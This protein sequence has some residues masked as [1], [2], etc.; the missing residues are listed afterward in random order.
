MLTFGQAAGAAPE[1]AGP[2]GTT[3]V[4]KA[5]PPTT[6]GPT[7]TATGPGTATGAT[8]TTT[9]PG[10][11]TTGADGEEEPP[12]SSDDDEGSSS[13]DEDGDGDSIWGAAVLGL[14][15]FGLVLAYFF[16][17][18]WRSSYEKLAKA[19]LEETHIFPSTVWGERAYGS[20]D[21]AKQL[22]EEGREPPEQPVVSGPAALTV[23]QPSTYKAT[24]GG[25]P[26]SD[27]KW[28]I[29]SGEIATVSPETGAEVTVTATKEGSFILS[30]ESGEDPGGPITRLS[31][32]AVAKSGEGGGVPLLGTNFA[33]VSIVIFAVAVTGG[34]VALGELSAEA[35]IAFLGPVIGYFFVR[36]NQSSST[37]GGDTGGS[38]G[39]SPTK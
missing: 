23:G 31:L 18:R 5:E 1:A 34:L 16:Y 14:G 29:D 32:T 22:F 35:F 6:T 9:G 3:D 12:S 28:S 13:S 7:T 38:T 2:T 30:A 39:N 15:A 21:Q 25:Q 36:P 11:T 10:G 33:P 4:A 8:T 37:V 17:D 19:T 20:S 26:F 24:R 27:C